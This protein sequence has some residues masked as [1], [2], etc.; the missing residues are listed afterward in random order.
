MK[1]RGS[2]YRLSTKELRAGLY[3]KWN[4]YRNIAKTKLSKSA[5]LKLEWIIFLNTIGEGKVSP[6]ARHFGINP[7][8][9]HKWKNRFDPKNL[10]SL[11]EYSRRPLNVR[12]WR[13]SSL[14]EQRITVLRKE[15]IKLGKRKLKQLYLTQYREPISTWKIERVIRRNNIYPEKNKH[16]Y[17]VEKRA[18]NKAKLRIHTIKDTVRDIRQFGF[19]WHIDAVIIWWYGTRKVIFTA[20]E[21]HARIAYAQVYKSNTASFA[22]DFLNKLNLVSGEKIRIMHSDN[23]SEFKG[24]FQKACLTLGILQVY[25]R[26]YTPKDNA[27]LERFNRT[28]QEEW[29]EQSVIGLDDIQE[30]NRDLLTWLIYYNSIRP[31]QAL[32]YMTPLQYAQDNFFKVLPMWSASTNT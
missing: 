15:N 3:G 17:L 6:T 21:Q 1:K 24:A 13:V 20:I 18:K 26:A 27:V 22:E 30:A 5:Q 29:L 4:L 25:S 10:Y 7:K 14:E 11:E 2:T 31:H 12:Q 19:L 28:I 23:G 16:K 8:T 9:L 32:D